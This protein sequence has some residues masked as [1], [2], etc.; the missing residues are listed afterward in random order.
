MNHEKNCKELVY[1]RARDILRKN[2]LKR[3]KRFEESRTRIFQD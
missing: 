3:Q 2:K 1:N